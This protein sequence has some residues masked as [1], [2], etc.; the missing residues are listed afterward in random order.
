MRKL[1]V[2]FAL[3]ASGLSASARTVDTIVVTGQELPG[4]GLVYDGISIGLSFNPLHLNDRGEVAFV[5]STRNAETQEVGDAVVAGG[6]GSLRVAAQSGEQATGLAD[7]ITFNALRSV[8]FNNRGQLV[9]RSFLS[10][11]GLDDENDTG[12]WFEDHGQRILVAR[13]G[14]PAPGADADFEIRYGSLQ[15]LLDDD[16]NVAFPGR[17]GDL[18]FLT[19][20]G[21]WGGPP[22]AVDLLVIEGQSVPDSPDRVF[23]IPPF[24]ASVI[25]FGNPITNRDGVT[26]F[27]TFTRHAESL[28][29]DDTYVG[30]IWKNTADGLTPIMQTSDAVPGVANGVQFIPALFGL[31]VAVF[32]FNDAEQVVFNGVLSGE[33]VEESNDWGVWIFGDGSGQLVAREGGDVPGLDGVRFDNLASI[34][35]VLNNAG[36]TTFIGTLAGV[37]VDGSNDRAIWRAGVDEELRLVAREGGAAT[38]FDEGVV[39][40]SFGFALGLNDV[41]QLVFSGTVAGPGI[42]DTN[43]LAY[44]LQEEDGGIELI[45]RTGDTFEVLPGEQRVVSSLLSTL[46]VNNT[47]SAIGGGGDASTFNNQSQLIFE[48]TFTDGSSGL[49]LLNL[50]PIPEPSSA[51]LVGLGMSLFVLSR[52]G[53]ASPSKHLDSYI[54]EV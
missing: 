34:A 2:I 14:S 3:V 32:D 24:P 13:D 16:G 10:G 25:S 41:G 47:R 15:A 42:D 29:F 8:D 35:P 53:N 27:A 22:A 28:A 44:W 39:F 31:G 20:F 17:V 23:G 50:M 33:G 7:G 36:Q 43:N 30:G 52:R 18:P 19:T 45:L 38:G 48:A 37:G 46:S 4:T 40:E 5:A 49:F 26:A 9:F 12:I 21:I 1:A 11:P 54:G 51:L 6:P